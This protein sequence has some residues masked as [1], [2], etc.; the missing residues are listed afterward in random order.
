MFEFQKN[1]FTSF[2]FKVIMSF[3]NSFAMFNNIGPIGESFSMKTETT[4]RSSFK[5]NTDSF[6]NAM[7]SVTFRNVTQETIHRNAR[8]S[9]TTR[10]PTI[11]NEL[12][13]QKSNNQ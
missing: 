6:K 13:S 12:L 2:F 11:I 1:I 8:R 4:L 7:C 3:Q 5:E 10:R 9:T